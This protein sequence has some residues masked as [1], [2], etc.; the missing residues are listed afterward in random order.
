[1]VVRIMKFLSIYANE[2]VRLDISVLELSLSRCHGIRYFITV[3]LVHHHY[4][5]LMIG[6]QGVVMG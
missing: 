3:R 5:Q 1:M 4:P 2:L 6:M